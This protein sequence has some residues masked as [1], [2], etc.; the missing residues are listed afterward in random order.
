MIPREAGWTFG[1][2]LA[3]FFS[4]PV[5]SLVIAL[6]LALACE[7]WASRTAHARDA[8]AP[9]S[10]K[11]IH[12]L[13]AKYRSAR[14]LLPAVG[15]VIIVWFV[16]EVVVRGYLVAVPEEL[17][18]VR[19]VAPIIGAALGLGAVLVQI[20]VSGSEVPEEPGALVPRRT[21]AS[22]SEP[23]DLIGA[24]FV[25]LVLLT[26]TIAA[27]M[28][29]SA[30]RWGVSDSVELPVPNL[31]MVDPIRLPFFGWAYG[32]PVL[33]SAGILLLVVA[34]LLQKNASRSF[35]RPETAMAE[36]I[37]RR[38]VGAGGVRI[39]TAA[40]LLALAASW[41]LIAGAGSVSSLEIAGENDG[42]PYEVVWRFAE[43]ATAAGWGAPIAEVVALTLLLLVVIRY[44]RE[45]AWRRLSHDRALQYEAAR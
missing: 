30:D 15:I 16:G 1:D 36:R 14:A 20:V 11:S 6:F 18:W 8:V 29:A 33:V 7:A 17:S 34:A 10:A 12:S 19:F 13:R 43:F 44:S 3:V 35:I 32:I 5:T 38:Q 40:F 39:A 23:R 2:A 4:F 9:L 28:A 22:F 41:R 31:A 27:G 45:A 42:R 24:L 25:V 21:W 26:T 37:V